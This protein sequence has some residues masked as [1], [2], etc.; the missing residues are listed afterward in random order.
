M[1][2]MPIFSCLAW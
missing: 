2:K 1:M